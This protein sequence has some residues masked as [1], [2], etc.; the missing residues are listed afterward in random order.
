MRIAFHRTTSLQDW[1]IISCTAL[2]GIPT[3]A[4]MRSSTDEV[5]PWRPVN[6]T[7]ASNLEFAPVFDRNDLR[8]IVR[9]R[10]T[11]VADLQTAIPQGQL[12]EPKVGGCNGAR[13]AT[14]GRSAQ[15]S[16]GGVSRDAG[17][18]ADTRAGAQTVGTG[19][20]VVRGV[21]HRPGRGQLSVS[22]G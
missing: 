6:T 16:P 10:G 11:S 22:N 3:A 1:C 20:G 21:A 18:A 4:V 5:R 12:D 17:P 8:T 13:A 7:I 15:A 2:I 14:R 19:C 9:R